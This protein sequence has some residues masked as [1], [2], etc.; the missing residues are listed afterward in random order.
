MDRD[1]RECVSFFIKKLKFYLIFCFPI[2]KRLYL[3]SIT[4]SDRHI[5]KTLC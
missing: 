4:L 5:G 1:V 3:C 2:K